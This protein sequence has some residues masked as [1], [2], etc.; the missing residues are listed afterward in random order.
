L[1]S[2]W[3]ESYDGAK[4]EQVEVETFDGK[5]TRCKVKP[6]KDSKHEGKGIIRIPEKIQLNLDIKKGELVRLKPAV[7]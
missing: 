7:D 2:Q 6:I 4:I 3:E 5:R 1:L